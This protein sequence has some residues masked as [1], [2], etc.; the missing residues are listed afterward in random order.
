MKVHN[1][2]IKAFGALLVAALLFAALPTGA[3][4]ADAGGV[5][6]AL[7]AGADRLVALQNNDG[8]WDWPLDDGNPDNASP[9]NT[10]G[11]IGMGLAQAY[12]HTGDSAHLAALQ[13]VGTFLLNKTVFS[14]SDGYLA[15]QLDSIFGVTTYTSHLQTN[16][17]DKLAAGTYV[18]SDG[19]TT[20]D[21][22]SYVNYIRNFRTGKSAN[23]A[24]WDLGYSVVSAALCGVSGTELDYWINGLKAEI[25]E[26][27]AYDDADGL[28]MW[29]LTDGL[30]G[31]IYGLSF[32][33]EEFDPTSGY[34]AGKTN[35][36][37]IADALLALQNSSG[38]FV[39][40]PDYTLEN[41]Q[42]ESTQ[43]TAY[44]IIALHTL[45]HNA[46]L[47]QIQTAADYLM[48]IQ[49]ATGGWDNY[50]AVGTYEASGE[51]NEITAEALWG[52]RLAYPLD[53]IW[54]C[55]TGDCGHP[56]AQFATIQGAIDAASVGAT[57]NVEPGTYVEGPIGDHALV[58]D[59]PNLTVKST[60]GRD[61]TIIDA[62]GAR[63]GI[64]VLENLGTVTFEGFTVQN[65]V[66]NGIVQSYTQRENTRFDVLNNLVKPTD[67]YLRNGIQ[68]SGDYSEVKG[69][70]VYG[71]PM[72]ETWSS[73][74]IG[75]INATGVV[76]SGNTIQEDPVNETDPELG[77]NIQTHSYA[78]PAIANN[79][80]IE[81][82]YV[83]NASSAISI[84]AT[85]NDP[86]YPVTNITIDNN[87]FEENIRA[88]NV[89]DVA[90]DGLTIT[91]NIIGSNRDDLLDVDG[92]QYGSGIWFSEESAT[93]TN[94]SITG[95]T[96]TDNETY[97]VFG[98]SGALIDTA[99]VLSTNTFD[100]AV[101]IEGEPVIYSTI[102]GAIDAASDGDII[103]VYPGAY[104]EALE[105][106]TPNIT[107]QSTGGADVTIIDVPFGSLTTGVKVLANMGTVTF[108][109]FTVKDFTE[110]G[111][112]QGMSA[113]EGT[114]FHVL[115]NKV[116]T[117]V[118]TDATA[119]YLR[120]GIQ[121]S[122]DGSTVIGNYVEGAYLT[123]D[124]GSTG[125]LVV[126]ASNVD[127]LN[128]EVNATSFGM[129]YGIGIANWSGTGEMTNIQIIGN[130]ITAADYPLD[131]TAYAGTIG[132]GIVINENKVTNYIEP[133]W[134]G[135]NGGVS[136]AQVDATH[137]W[138]G[139]MYGPQGAVTGDVQVIQWCADET[140]TTFLP[141]EN[142]EIHLSGNI[143]VPGGIQVN[144]P[145]VT[146]YLANGTVIQNS[147]A[148]FE[149]NADYT[150]I[151]TESIGGAVCKPT[152]D[153]NGINVN[154]DRLN[155]V[156]EGLE[157]D[158]SEQVPVTTG[159]TPNGI[160]FDGT[161]TD[162]V[163]RDNFIHEMAGDGMFFAAQP[164]GTVQI[165][166]N[167]FKDNG[168]NG[169]EA[170]A[171]N[172]PA[173]YNAWGHVNGAAAG[174]G[175]SSGVDADP[176]T[177]VDLYMVSTNPDVDNW[178]NQV[179]V[180]GTI[181]YQVKT[182]MVNA[183]SADFEFSYPTGLLTNPVVANETTAFIPPTGTELVIVDGATGV[184]SFDGFS[185]SEV[186][187]DIVLFEVTFDAVGTAGEAA[188]D[189]DDTT[190]LFGMSPST[191]PSNNIY[192]TELVDSTLDVIDRPVLTI[193]SGLDTDLIAGLSRQIDSTITN[194]PT[195]GE[196]IESIGD[197]PP[198]DTVGWIRISDVK[199][200]EIAELQFLWQVDGEWH[201]FTVQ[202]AP[203]YPALQEIG[204][205]VIA[206][207][208]N[209][210]FG[211]EILND[212]SD[213]DSYR[214][215]FKEP[216]THTI[217]VEI[218]DM[219]DEPASYGNG[220][221]LTSFGPVTFDVLGNFDVTGTISMQGRSVRSGVPV[222]LTTG[223]YDPITATT[224]NV[225][226]NNLLFT[227]VNGGTYTITTLQPRYLNITDAQGITVDI[228][229]AYTFAQS[230]ELK[231]GNAF[232]KTMIEQEGVLV[233]DGTYDNSIDT[234]DAS[235]VGTQYGT[236]GAG[237]E[238][239]S[240]DVNF[241][242]IVNILD[243]SLVGGNFL[244][245]STV[246]TS[247][248]P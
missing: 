44:A 187:G 162:L 145:G 184:I 159:V 33:G 73:T 128:N 12:F 117:Y 6:P 177:H 34:V 3:A 81:Y 49:L 169:I 51:N 232:W 124:Y 101:V 138:W 16:F 107:V 106:H 153:D 216:G 151:T 144:V 96:F 226:S 212:W 248:T 72:D 239:N 194:P 111:I 126:N 64:W 79:V 36:A 140:C 45:D 134:V 157:I 42:N 29:Y 74:G 209:W 41:D 104:E 47:T 122:G 65:F 76:V 137:N 121:V 154:G 113:R 246:Y 172:I 221:L 197:T 57:I 58:L 91:N 46:Y 230:L 242:G 19:V 228:A 163:V 119:P 185:L 233:W 118:P 136:V 231:G 225:I 150:T 133:L 32:V 245:D 241:D 238:D 105:L 35:L 129:D 139:S 155:I 78:Y 229:G 60:A 71:A 108:D 21:T 195:G 168:G 227:G 206:R 235:V 22:E 25:D 236:A 148:C 31:G 202:D 199:I 18:G 135:V 152:G 222:T 28:E 220:I 141:D 54:V 189:F 116:L 123:E 102:Q 218:Y 7:Q 68:V 4:K 62:G 98:H 82:N 13:D 92:P 93:A 217:T 131:V 161:V 127:V 20:F 160:D 125:I 2:F 89:Q 88:I 173:E 112:I 90:L 186:T 190:D 48:S 156:I 100:K 69:N 191:G 143:N 243:L 8:G 149:V 158:G 5:D 38:G 219:L 167:L 170:G 109:G 97:Q 75:V 15:V 83:R 52:I 61:V 103:N 244:E 66:Q 165:Q 95:N 142:N 84:A 110:S 146:Y 24:A 214:I 43:K 240:G 70:T 213:S 130:T 193:T 147:S 10:I 203:G 234:S 87:T 208:C 181:T 85:E 164:A 178:L 247:W 171:F 237:M 77:I 94:V 115:N 26:L 120:N 204:D 14:G 86:V 55:P 174:D 80:T 11:P 56:G 63:D 223:L 192:A 196:W 207:F 201:D 114:T 132:A 99:V 175:I 198:A 37:G 67:G 205:D 23:L 27:E 166:G 182:H 50:P 180:D 39:W 30:A 215:T 9:K 176:Y 188:L 183:T 224:I 40:H 200:N 17:Y 179:F 59:V 211:C 210:E 53:E 1:Y